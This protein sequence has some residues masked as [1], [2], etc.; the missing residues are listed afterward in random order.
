LSFN[1]FDFESEDCFVRHNLVKNK[2]S[3]IKILANVLNSAATWRY[4]FEL[5]GVTLL[6][7]TNIEELFGIIN[8]QGLFDFTNIYLWF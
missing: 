2:L 8:I 3:P 4:Y 7:I 1:N 5:I 6:K